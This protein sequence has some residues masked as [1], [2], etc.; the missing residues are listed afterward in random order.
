MFGRESD[1]L[2]ESA[3]PDSS[4]CV[5]WRGEKREDQGPGRA[6][7]GVESVQSSTL[8]EEGAGTESAVG[9]K[10]LQCPLC[11]FPW[12]PKRGGGYC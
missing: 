10:N 1:A 3:S 2:T 5:R 6:W 7:G 8:P 4:D 9:A 11:R 12:N